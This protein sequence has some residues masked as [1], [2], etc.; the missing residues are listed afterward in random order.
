MTTVRPEHH[1]RDGSQGGGETRARAAPG[2][3]REDVGGPHWRPLRHLRATSYLWTSRAR[4]VA[5]GPLLLVIGIRR[6]NRLLLGAYGFY[7][8]EP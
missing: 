1:A 3:A 8:R 4:S 6:P 2:A 7:N 5:E